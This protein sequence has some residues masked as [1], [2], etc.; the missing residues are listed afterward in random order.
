MKVCPYCAEEVQDAAVVCRHCGRALKAGKS[1]TLRGIVGSG[2]LIVLLGIGG[3]TLLRGTIQRSPLG[4][5]VVTLT[6]GESEIAPRNYMEWAWSVD[7]RRP[8]CHVHA[9]FHGVAGGNRD[10]EVYLFDGNGMTNWKNGTHPTTYY[11]SGRVSAATVDADIQGNG[12]KYHLVV[13]NAFSVV[14]SKTVELTSGQVTC[15]AF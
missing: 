3:L 4:H 5:L 11:S 15:S 8:D 1:R 2:V 7:P 10:F 9:G 14:S 12:P 6:P 13:S